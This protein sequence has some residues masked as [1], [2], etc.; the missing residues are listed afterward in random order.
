MN[1]RL[2]AVWKQVGRIARHEALTAVEVQIRY[3]EEIASLLWRPATLRTPFAEAGC[4]SLADRR[5]EQRR[6]HRCH[7]LEP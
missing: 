3:S 6:K 5:F 1:Q 7:R 2:L 4:T